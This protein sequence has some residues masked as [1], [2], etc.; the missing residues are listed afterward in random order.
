[1]NFDQFIHVAELHQQ[2]LEDSKS[3]M[4][5][6]EIDDFTHVIINK[7][8]KN[9]MTGTNLMKGTDWPEWEKSEFLQLNQYE[10]QQMFDPPGPIPSDVKNFSILPM[11]WVYLVK[12]DGRKKARCVANGAPHLKGTI[13]LAATYA[14]CLDQSANRLFWSF[15]AIKCKQVFGADAQNAFAEA[16]PPKAPLYLKIDAAFRNWWHH[17]TNEWINPDSYVRVNHAI[18][19]HPESPRLWNIHI[20]GILAKMGYTPTTH[21][22]CIYVKHTPTESLYLLRQVDD[23]AFACD[24]VKTATLFWD[25]LD[26]YLKAPLKREK[27]RITRHNG[28]DILQSEDGI[29]IYAETYLNKILAT[30]S[31]DMTITQ[32]KP[33]PM[34]S[35]KDISTKLEMTIGPDDA[36]EQI[37]LQQ[38]TGFKYRN[39]T[40]E[41]IFAMVTCRADIAF[42]VMKLSQYNNRPALCHFNAIME[43]Y[44]YLK[45]TIMDGLMYWR[46]RPCPQLPTTGHHEPQEEPYVLNMP[47]E[48][49]CPYTAYGMADSDFAGDRK[50]RKS[51]G[52]TLIFLGGAAIVYKTILQRTIALSSTEAEFYALSEAG[53]LV[54][55]IRFV[56]E[57]LDMTQKGPTTIYEDNRGC[58]QMTQALKP[59]KRTRHVETRYFAILEWSQTDQVK[60]KKIDTA[61]NASDNLTKP[62]GRILFY[63]HTDTIL[64]KRKPLYIRK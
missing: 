6:E 49:K 19:G 44:K 2:I 60:I 61:D 47:E 24:D 42:P 5:H 33:L 12:T 54:L 38:E 46:P 9:A 1:M 53:K 56:L 25:E 62:N 26:T 32:N 21:E 39:A 27:G 31:F 34:S 52:G 50:T 15:A 43:V 41:L 59:T 64:G 48:S 40:G 37:K 23:F 22:P 10:Q 18:Q 7:L 55:Y 63:R 51:V 17:K 20:D 57:D 30:K 28:I 11:I 8:S 4:L 3:I 35:D 36:A 29:K 58:L 45:V 16:P 13:T 14:A